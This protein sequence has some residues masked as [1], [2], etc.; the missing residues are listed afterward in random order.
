VSTDWQSIAAAKLLALKS[1]VSRSQ[2]LQQRL[3]DVN[4]YCTIPQWVQRSLHAAP[5]DQGESGTR[6]LRDKQFAVESRRA[7]DDHHGFHS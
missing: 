6:A 1:P 2:R 3:R 5:G 7:G 4:N